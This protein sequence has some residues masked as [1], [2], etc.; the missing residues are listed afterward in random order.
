MLLS[1]ESSQQSR[2]CK[3]SLN[4]WR[5]SFPNYFKQSEA[6]GLILSNAEEGKLMQ[7]T[8]A[9]VQVVTV[10]N[11]LMVHSEGAVT[12]GRWTS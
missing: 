7:F 8:P 4:H 11:S 12:G 9:M 6:F 5:Q 2:L 1:P 10:S 3:C